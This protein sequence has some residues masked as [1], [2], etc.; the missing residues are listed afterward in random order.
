M[1]ELHEKH[2]IGLDGLDLTLTDAPPSPL[3]T[4][5]M[6]DRITAGR[7][8]YTNTLGWHD[9]R[10]RSAPHTVQHVHGTSMTQEQYL[11]HRKEREKETQA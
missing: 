5:D 10:G 6:I 11:T 9:P 7:L 4:S 1:P 8:D 2:L 3:V